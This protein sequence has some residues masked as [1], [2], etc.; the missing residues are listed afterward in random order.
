MSE[1]PT[2]TTPSLR[3]IWIK[4]AHRGPMDPADR[5]TLV[6][7]KGLV[8]NAD[9]GRRRQVT[10]IQEEV[11]RKVTHELAADVPPTFRRA[12]LMVSGTPLEK[13]RGRIL[14]IGSCRLRV[15]GETVPC[16]LMDIFHQGLRQTLRPRWR[17][18]VFAEVLDGGEI[19]VGDP[20]GWEEDPQLSLPAAAQPSAVPSGEEP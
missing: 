8:G 12:N 9:Q 2:A 19:A 16:N 13:T 6:A 10:L 5:A 14:R 1:I 11:W 17:G 20:I 3:A 7:G 18:G 15:L 4:R